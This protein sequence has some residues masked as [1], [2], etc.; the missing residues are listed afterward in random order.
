M[1]PTP[2]GK[3]PPETEAEAGSDFRCFLEKSYS[4]FSRILFHVLNEHSELCTPI[5]NVVEAN[6]IRPAELQQFADCV[7]NDCGPQMPH[8][9][10][11]SN[12]WRGEVDNHALLDERRPC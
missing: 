2:L 6:D 10:F 3:A 9:H 5:S 11:L 8:M 7:S 12:V 1:C 4:R